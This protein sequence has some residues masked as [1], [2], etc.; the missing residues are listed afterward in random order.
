VSALLVNKGSDLN[1]KITWPEGTGRKNLTNY[2]V[3]LY[4]HTEGLDQHLT[5]TITDPNNGEITGR[6]NWN[7][8]FAMGRN[9]KFRVRINLAGETSS[10]P[11]IWI[12]VI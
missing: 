9:F 11:P 8:S 10:T 12:E 2:I 6:L 4:D 3:E 1:F 5:L 7:E